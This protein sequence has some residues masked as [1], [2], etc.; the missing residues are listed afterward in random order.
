MDVSSVQKTRLTFALISTPM[1][2][3]QH[4]IVKNTVFS[5]WVPLALRDWDWWQTPM[6][7]APLIGITVM[8]I[9]RTQEEKFRYYID[10]KPDIEN[11]ICNKLEN[12]IRVSCKKL[13]KFLTPNA[14]AMMAIDNNRG[15]YQKFN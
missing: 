9:L 15:K 7:L 3:L 4:D 2:L 11:Q 13:D 6:L 8:H 1:I 5:D 14:P 10:K 12:Q